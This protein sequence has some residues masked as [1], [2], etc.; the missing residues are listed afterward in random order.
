MQLG[1]AVLAPCLLL[2]F[3]SPAVALAH[4]GLPAGDAPFFDGDAF[5]GGD[6]EFGLL[7]FEGDVPVLASHDPIGAGINELV[8][9]PDGGVLATTFEG[10]YRTDDAGCS[11]AFV[12][13]PVGTEQ[14]R[15]LRIDPDDPDRLLA[16]TATPGPN[17]VL[18]SRDGGASWA[19]LGLQE[20]GVFFRPLL[21][22]PDGV[23]VAGGIDGGDGRDLVFVSEDGGATWRQPLA[24]ETSARGLLPL[25]FHDGR[26]WFGERFP[27]GSGAL[28]S[29]ADL[30]ETTAFEAGFEAGRPES[31][32]VVG[33]TP[34]VLVDST[35][36][37]RQVAPGEFLIDGDAP[38]DCFGP[39]RGEELW[40][41]GDIDI[42][43]AF[44]TTT[45]GVAFE[46]VVSF[47]ELCPRSCP[48]G[49]RGAVATAALFEQLAPLGVGAACAYGA[50]EPAPPPEPP[51][52][53][54]G[55]DCGGAA[56]LLLVPLP[57]AARREQQREQQPAAGPADR[58]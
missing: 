13:S 30:G 44:L 22:G 56:W 10:F 41:C 48:A 47:D 50:P 6:M 38:R 2:A 53:P 39:R 45:D 18:E 34:I 54:D 1:W 28:W 36:L 21:L 29:S 35:F 49:S 26:L 3:T 23:L 11:W 55:C 16:T 24:T 19:W 8:R 20:P 9:L 57:L 4:G 32:A 46:P 25:A 5:V 51:A 33:G 58:G 37:H 15:G 27:E 12:E 52:D 42:G 43:A 31:L 17:G 7:S 40:V 14:I